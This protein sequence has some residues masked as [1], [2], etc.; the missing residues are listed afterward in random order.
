[1]EKKT[2]RAVNFV[3]EETPGRRVALAGTFNDWKPERVLTDR[4]GDG[5]Y[6]VRMMLEPGEYQYKFVVDD[7]WRLDPANPNFVPN[8]FGSLNS[9][10]IVK[11]AEAGKAAAPESAPAPESRSAGKPRRTARKKK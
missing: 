4:N 9:I 8:N 5:V 2:L 10:L 6:R 1:M 11:P 3:L 7:E